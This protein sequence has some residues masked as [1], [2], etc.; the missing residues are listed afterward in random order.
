MFELKWLRI[1][2]MNRFQLSKRFFENNNIY[3]IHYQNLILK[4]I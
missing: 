3:I 4:V 2:L 1:G